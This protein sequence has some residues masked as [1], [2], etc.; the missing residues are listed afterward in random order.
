MVDVVPPGRRGFTLVEILIVVVILGVLA[1]LVVP[2][3]AEASEEA[4]RSAFVTDLRWFTDAAVLYVNET[5]SFPEDFS[6]GTVSG[7]FADYVDADVW[8]RITPI[9]GRWDVERES[10]SV[11]SA[12]GVHFNGSG[13]SRDDDYMTPIDRLIDDGDLTTGSFRRLTSG[14]YYSVIR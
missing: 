4:K 9:G 1:G 13:T 10:M 14:R 8:T 11:T 12:I 6:T 5:G 3:L 7:D 2:Q